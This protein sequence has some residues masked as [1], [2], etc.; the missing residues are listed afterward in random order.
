[1]IFSL[2]DTLA[3]FHEAF[4]QLLRIIGCHYQVSSQLFTFTGGVSKDKLQAS[5]KDQKGFHVRRVG[6]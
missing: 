6:N 5:L 1:M 4:A 3:G 2:A